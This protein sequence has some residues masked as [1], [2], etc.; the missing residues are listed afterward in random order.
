VRR[1]RRVGRAGISRDRRDDDKEAHPMS[2]TDRPAINQLRAL[3]RRRQTGDV[4]RRVFLQGIAALGL[5][6]PLASLLERRGV[7]ALQATPEGDG[8]TPSGELTIVL[9]RSLVSLDPHGAQSVEEATAVISSH[10]FDTLLVRDPATGDLVPRL[11]TSWQALEPT[12]WEFKLREGVTWQD[13]SPF[14]S[15][16][17]KASLERVQTLAGPLAPLWSLVNAVETPDDL[18]VIFRT[19]EPQGTVPVSASLFFITPGAQSNNEGFFDNPVGIGPYRFVSWTRDAELRLEA[20]P[21][22]WGG[23][24]GI[25]TLIFRDIPEVAARVTALETG[26]I[27]FTWALP[28]D[29]LPALQENPNLVI[30]STS[31]YAYYFNWFNSKR[32]PFTDARVRQAMAYALDVDT[33]VND[34][35]QGVGVRAQAPIPSTIFGFAPQTPY[36]YDPDKAR[37]LLTEAGYPNGFQTH[38]IWNPGSGPQDRELIL[39][40]ISYWADIGVTVES[41][42][43]ERAAWLDALLALDWDMDFQTNTVRT[44]DADFTLRRLYVS[45][46]NRNGYANPDLDKLLLDAAAAS[47]PAKREE[48]YAQACKIIWDDAVG[49]FPFELLENYVH[50]TG[51][52]GF[53]P[54]PSAVPT[55]DTVTIVES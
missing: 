47:D 9:P 30:D 24:P 2:N 46:A 38:V 36:A 27:D 18:T 19:S 26:E 25:Q 22:Y 52:E 34:L 45:S 11:A 8:R 31:S 20:N 23:A 44:G 3:V 16:D 54:T 12:A 43:M 17:V 28:A 6:L 5:S 7:S 10:V 32:E 40:M 37:A 48:L 1:F 49:I 51:L 33:M 53:V 55:F 4:S 50:R 21:N 14:T 41:R 39:S 13:G 15:A 42:E 35:L 29:Q